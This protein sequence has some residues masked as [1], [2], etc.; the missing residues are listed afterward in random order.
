MKLY[1][2]ISKVEEQD[3]GTLK[4]YGFASSGA[5]DSEGEIV[6]P[7]AMKAAIPDYMKFGAVREMHQSI[8]AGT[9]IDASVDDQGRTNFAAHVVDPVAVKKV[10]ASVY[11]GFSIGG[12]VTARD[13]KNS[14]IITGLR[15]VE[16]SL[17]DR[18][19]NPEAVFTMYKAENPDVQKAAVNEL[20]ELVNAQKI[21]PTALLEVAKSHIAVQALR[22]TAKPGK[23]RKGM[24]GVA[25]FA[26]LLA[27]IGY[28][29]QDSENEEAWEGDGSTMPMKLR[30]WLAAGVMIFEDMTT[31]ETTELL[32]S[33]KTQATGDSDMTAAADTGIDTAKAG[34]KFSQDTKD[35]MADMHKAMT[36]MHEQVKACAKGMK[37][38]CDK[39]AGMGWQDDKKDD[40]AAMAAKPGD[41]AKKG[42]EALTE[43]SALAKT[44]TDALGGITA[45]LGDLAKRVKAVE[46]QPAPAKGALN[47][48]AVD[49]S[50]D[51]ATG[52]E[53][54]GM[55]PVMKSDGTV[56]EAATLVK[57]IHASGGTPWN[58]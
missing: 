24:Y 37:D 25:C 36:D 51:G 3:D 9:A 45:Q 42:T 26:Q 43:F 7:D 35:K 40:D 15:L 34:A 33:L 23:L 28:L 6:S 22:A 29:A 18:P 49:K 11:K 41:V 12:K 46:D 48:V 1:A 56:D 47:A 17:V 2:S 38:C 57:V 16:V 30:D 55:R 39:L 44:V 13:E 21:A 5:V 52:S 50:K 8:A 19:A 4:V 27:Q 54:P 58:P 20:G 32:A 31:E 10:K 14:K 53:K